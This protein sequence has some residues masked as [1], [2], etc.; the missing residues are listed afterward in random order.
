MKKILLRILGLIVVWILAWLWVL[1]YAS[2][3]YA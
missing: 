3:A 1:L 2:P